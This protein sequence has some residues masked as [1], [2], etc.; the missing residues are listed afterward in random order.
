MLPF[1]NLYKIANI[2]LNNFK[3]DDIPMVADTI[4]FNN[5][6]KI[7]VYGKKI[8][9]K[10][11]EDYFDGAYS[12]LNHDNLYLAGD[13]YKRKA[14][15]HQYIRSLNTTVYLIS[16]DP[17]ARNVGTFAEM[18]N[19]KR[20]E[21]CRTNDN[22]DVEMSELYY[23]ML[24]MVNEYQD[25]VEERIPKYADID[26]PE[27]FKTARLYSADKENITVSIVYSFN[28][29]SRYT[30]KFTEL[31]KFKGTVIYGDFDKYDEMRFASDVFI[32]LFSPRT[33]IAD[34]YNKSK[35]FYTDNN[36]AKV[37]FIMVSK[38]NMKRLKHL[39]DIC[40]IDDIYKRF[41]KRKEN[42]VQS[43]YHIGK[44]SVKYSSLDPFY[45]SSDFKT[46]FPEIGVKLTALTDFLYANPIKHLFKTD[47]RLSLERYFKIDKDKK[48]AK[49]KEYYET[50]TMI[51]NICNKYR[52]VFQFINIPNNYGHNP[53]FSE[54]IKSVI[55]I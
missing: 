24:D 14:V 26:V 28:N 5:L 3:Y 44:I 17:F 10:S 48:H 13:D 25:I 51:N 42:M 41:F 20:S 32:D 36:K 31:A 35:G 7:I 2:K 43:S 16:A 6:Y 55:K 50:I 46:I 4:L 54:F 39:K 19:V 34:R 15:K 27:T 22:G 21:L 29:I 37:M 38:V 23:K 11:K 12:Q 18:F 30:M 40:S 33:D 52:N 45:R 47:E 1:G 49:N 53:E 8:T 9:S